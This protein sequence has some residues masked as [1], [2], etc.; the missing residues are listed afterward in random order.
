MSGTHAG[1]AHDRARRGAATSFGESATANRQRSVF[2]GQI[3][4]DF[5]TNVDLDK[6]GG[7]PCHGH[8]LTLKTALLRP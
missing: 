5:E 8:I 7:S 4:V 1:L 6:R 3:A 2:G